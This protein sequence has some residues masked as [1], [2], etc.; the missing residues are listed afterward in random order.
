M[1]AK[2]FFLELFKKENFKCPKTHIV[3][4]SG[5]SSC[6]NLETYKNWTKSFS[7]ASQEIPG[8]SPSSVMGHK[9]EIIFLT[10]KQSQAVIS[11]QV[12]RIHGYEGHS[13]R[14]CTSLIESLCLAGCKNF[15]LTNAAG[16]LRKNLSPGTAMVLTDHINFTGQN[17]LIGA[18]PVDE[19]KKE[20]GTRF[21][22]MS[23]AYDKKFRDLLKIKLQEQNTP[24]Y[25]GVYLGV[26]GPNF[27][28]AAEISA[29]AKLGADAVGM[30]TVWENLILK[31]LGAKVAGLSFISNYGT[32]LCEDNPSHDEVLELA[33]IN[34]PKINQALLNFAEEI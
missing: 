8:G 17:P 16:S 21:P 13:P 11:L 27:E 6:L 2:E 4:G 24:C 9:G 19:N 33:A 28:T 25:Q 1:I 5:L 30:S 29:F 7:I 3:L 15:V 23:H 32:G 18:I 34:G 10:H 20:L 14:S 31:F 22:D 12:G 26:M